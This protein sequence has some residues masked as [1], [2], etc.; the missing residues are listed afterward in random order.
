MTEE[1][2]LA[3]TNPTPMLEFLQEKASERKHCLFA[4]AAARL[5]GSDLEFD[6][7]DEFIVPRMEIVEIFSPMTGT[8]YDR[9]VPDVPPFVRIGSMVAPDSAVCIIESHRIFNRVQS[10]VPGIV[11]RILVKHQEF[12]HDSRPLFRIIRAP[13]VEVDRYRQESV[14][15]CLRDIFGNPFRPVAIDPRW[16]TSTV[17]DLAGGIYEERAFERMP[18]L[19]DALMDAGCDNEEIIAHCRGDG[20]HVRGCWVVDLLLGKE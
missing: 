12:V 10:E 16:L 5:F 19:A 9:P 6:S 17:V 8:F 20:P 1:E 4:C 3:S 11:I 14:T 13:L 18:I 2:W 15:N 7:G